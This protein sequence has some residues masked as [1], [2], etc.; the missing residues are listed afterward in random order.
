MPDKPITV[1]DVFELPQSDTPEESSPRWQSLRDWMNREVSSIKKGSVPDLT[2]KVAELLE[3]PLPDILLTSWKKT[4]VLRDLLEESRKSPETAH[5]LE[6]GEHVINSQHR[7]HIEV[8]VKRV[9]VKKLE[10]LLRLNFKLKGFILKVQNGAVTEMQ[11]GSC[12]MKGSLEF[13]G[14][15]VAEKKLSPIKLPG[16]ISLEAMRGMW[17]T[18]KPIS[19]TALAAAAAAGSIGPAAPLLPKVPGQPTV[20]ST[21]PKTPIPSTPASEPPSA[22]KGNASVP[23][24]MSVQEARTG[25]AGVSPAVREPEART[26]ATPVIAAATPQP[27]PPKPAPP[28]ESKPAPP[29]A[30]S[31][32]SPAESKSASTQT[33]PAAPPKPAEER[34]EFVL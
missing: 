5:Y 1:R 24:A 8:K 11:T 2:A 26:A 15:S 3:V 20:P 22:P 4:N 9:S 27:P 21:S 13:Q 25:T 6:L 28:A 32:A 16:R 17:E 34:E 10:F 23:P 29:P 7:P 33:A 19:P 12:D 18:D 30:A 14:L 31:A